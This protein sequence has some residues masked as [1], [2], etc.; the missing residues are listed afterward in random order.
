MESSLG[1]LLV[2]AFYRLAAAAR[3]IMWGGLY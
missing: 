2:A 3:F 1:V